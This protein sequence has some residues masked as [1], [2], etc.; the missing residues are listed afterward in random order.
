M[1]RGNL[2][3]I[4]TY[5]TEYVHDLVASGTLSIVGPTQLRVRHLSTYQTLDVYPTW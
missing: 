2:A 3:L 1:V 4:Q 5:S